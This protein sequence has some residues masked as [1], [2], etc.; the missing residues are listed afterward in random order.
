MRITRFV[1]WL[2]LTSFAL[3]AGCTTSKTDSEQ[4]Q[5]LMNRTSALEQQV[6]ALKVAN[7]QLQMQVRALQQQPQGPR[8]PIWGP[9]QIPLVPSSPPQN[10]PPPANQPPRLTPIDTK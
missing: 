3:L 9:P 7:D 1:F 6:H 10:P 2:S 4:L 5:Q 8:Q